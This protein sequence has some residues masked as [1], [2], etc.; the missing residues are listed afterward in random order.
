MTYFCP[1]CGHELAERAHQGVTLDVCTQCQGIWLDRGELA[2]VI[3][4]ARRAEADRVAAEAPRRERPVDDFADDS[5]DD[6]WP[7]ERR[8]RQR[9]DDDH[10]D[11]RRYGRRRS[12]FDR[13]GDIF[14]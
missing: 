10:D 7:T 12:F 11:D 13:L 6:G 14:D 1:K 4:A 5:S 3:G 8:R 9:D 2:K